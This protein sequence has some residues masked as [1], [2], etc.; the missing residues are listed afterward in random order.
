M[1]V[2]TDADDELHTPRPG[3]PTWAETC[4]FAA[5]VPERS[6]GIWTYPLFRTNLGVMSTSVYVWGPEGSELWQ[7]PYYRL[8]WHQPIP[9]GLRLTDFEA[10]T[11]LAYRRLEPL[12]S[13]EV[14]YTD[15]DAISLEMRFDAIHRPHELG[16]AEDYGHIDQLGRITGEL[17]L[18]GERIEIDCVEMRDRTWSP[19]RERRDRTWLTYSYGA[20]DGETAF[21]CA[22]R[23]NRELEQ[24][25]L[26]GFTLRGG[27]MHEL[28]EGRRRAERDAEGRPKR[29][30]VEGR[31]E[32]GAE[33]QVVGDVVSQ[34]AMHTSPYLCFISQVRWE[35]PD[36]S[37]AWGEDQDTWSPGLW[38]AL[39]SDLIAG[40]R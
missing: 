30:V 2:L 35:L 14:R 11:G 6:I 7:Q 38:R 25:L 27:A 3:D 23:V 22:T 26:G 32:T 4:W 29:I 28:T 34:M 19:R 1:S 15:G 39:R 17:V 8:Y 5:Q 10:P 9:E 12:T 16:I 13:Y 40:R 24:Q 31:D 37:I 33:V 36:G 18:H 20:V 21:H